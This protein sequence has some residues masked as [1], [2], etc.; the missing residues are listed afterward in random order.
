MFLQLE[1]C[2]NM[3]LINNNSKGQSL[4]EV[5][6]SLS[7]VVIVIT[8]ITYAVIS[9][10]QN[11]EFSKNQNFA[12]QFAQQGL[13]IARST[14]NSDYKLFSSL[15]GSYCVAST[16][17]TISTSLGDKCG[18]KSD[19]NGCGQN[20]DIFV[21]QVDFGR[22]S[23]TCGTIA[24]KVTST[25]AWADSKCTSRSNIFCHNVNLSTCLSDYLVLPTP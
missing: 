22:A 5:L 18:L 7:T 19:S 21:R 15:S 24:T 1:Q 25:V 6:V 16:C 20:I 4:I 17:S 23:A 13:E 14:R 11:A 12:T 3:P 8:S 2:N 10:L 9:A